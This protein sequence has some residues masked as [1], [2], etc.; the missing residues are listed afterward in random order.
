MDW[1]DYLTRIEGVQEREAFVDTLV[2]AA[3]ADDPPY[4]LDYARLELEATRP[5]EGMHG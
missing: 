2:E 5:G 4:V 3:A 1:A